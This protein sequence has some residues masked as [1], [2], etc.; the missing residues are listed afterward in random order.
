[1]GERLPTM[2]MPPSRRPERWR[3]MRSVA[4]STAMP[5]AERPCSRS[6]AS[7]PVTSVP[8]KMFHGFC[9]YCRSP[10]AVI[11]SVISMVNA[12]VKKTSAR[13]AKSSI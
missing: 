12:A 8:S 2:K 10:S 6:A 5:T 3:S 9:R 7:E 11:L 13:S 1:M 4:G